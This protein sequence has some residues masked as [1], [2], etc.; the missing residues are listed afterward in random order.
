M[1]INDK[2]PH[3]VSRNS[4]LFVHSARS[5]WRQIKYLPPPRRANLPRHRELRLGELRGNGSPL[6]LGLG[7]KLL[8]APLVIVVLYV[9]LLR[10]GGEVIRVT[11]FEAAMGPMIGG[12]IVAIQHRLN[13]PL[14]TLM[15]GLGITLSFLTLPAWWYGLQL[16]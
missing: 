6:A 13:P 9:G 4:V 3:R 16:L 10:A 12:A 5:L 14:I 1:Q 7:F 2:L 15:V 11:L 8:L